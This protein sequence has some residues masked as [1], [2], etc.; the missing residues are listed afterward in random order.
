MI[1]RSEEHYLAT[2]DNAR[3]AKLAIV[4]DYMDGR[5][6]RRRFVTLI[7][8]CVV[9]LVVALM[10]EAGIVAGALAGMTFGGVPGER[11]AAYLPGT[12]FVLYVLVSEIWMKIY[13]IKAFSDLKTIDHLDRQFAITRQRGVPLPRI[14]V[15]AVTDM[16]STVNA[17]Y[18]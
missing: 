3:W 6:Q 9:Q 8:L 13:R 5:W 16:S 17:N 10:V 12:L 4:V 14:E 18:C 1:A 7:L 2:R 15:K 11:L